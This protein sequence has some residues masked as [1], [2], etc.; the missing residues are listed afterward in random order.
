MPKSKDEFTR[1]AQS[2]DRSTEDGKKLF[3]AL[4]RL[5]QGFSDLIDS[6]EDLADANREAAEAA[7]EAAW[8][9]Q[10]ALLKAEEKA[11]KSQ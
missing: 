2:I 11:Q 1:L 9:Q 10:E 6:S 7:A 3:A 5:S 8:K 4:I